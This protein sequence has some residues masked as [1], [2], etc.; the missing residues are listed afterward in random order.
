MVVLAAA[1]EVVNDNHSIEVT[2]AA[3]TNSSRL[4]TEA[5]SVSNPTEA[6]EPITASGNPTST[7]DPDIGETDVSDTES[8][9]LD[10]R[11]AYGTSPS[12]ASTAVDWSSTTD[13][14]EMGAGDNIPTTLATGSADATTLTSMPEKKDD[15]SETPT[16]A[17]PDSTS[18]TL[19]DKRVRGPLRTLAKEYAVDSVTV[20]PSSTDLITRSTGAERESEQTGFESSVTTAPVPTAGGSGATTTGETV[21]LRSPYC[22]SVH[23]H[24]FLNCKH[25]IASL[26][27]SIC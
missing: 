6:T 20:S 8:L 21:S 16:A 9:R 14:N 18:D 19:T 5:P 25:Y 7:K 12:T 10:Y 15:N 2:A 4:M 26:S 3:R 11:T 13:T 27:F 1:A 17:I 23:G 24:C 22:N